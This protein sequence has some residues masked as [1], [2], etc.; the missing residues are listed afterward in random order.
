MLCASENKN[1]GGSKWTYKI[2][3]V[4]TINAFHDVNLN[5]IHGNEHS[6]QLGILLKLSMFF[7]VKT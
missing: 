1:H 6:P 7:V 4:N 5:V 3:H 2:E